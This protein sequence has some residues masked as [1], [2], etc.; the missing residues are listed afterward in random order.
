[1]CCNNRLI[2]THFGEQEYTACCANK[3][4]YNPETAINVNEKIVRTCCEKVPIVLEQ[5]YFFEMGVSG[6]YDGSWIRESPIKCCGDS[7]CPMEGHTVCDSSNNLIYQTCD[8]H[9][10]VTHN[11]PQPPGSFA[12]DCSSGTCKVV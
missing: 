1:M 6:L 7:D 9:Q 8:N 4:I 2:I 11:D 5:K 10:C 3:I 12:C